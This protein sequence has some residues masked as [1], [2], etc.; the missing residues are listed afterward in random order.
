MN[1]LSEQYNYLLDNGIS[2][3]DLY[4]YYLIINDERAYHLQESDIEQAVQQIMSMRYNSS[5]S[6]EEM[7][8]QFLDGD[9][10]EEEEWY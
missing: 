10:E 8:D 5:K 9:L 2:I 1:N 7:V 3:E 4:V 6:L